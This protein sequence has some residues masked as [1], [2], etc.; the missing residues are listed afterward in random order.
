M[1]SSFRLAVARR[2]SEMRPSKNFHRCGL[3]PIRA[4]RAEKKTDK[5]KIGFH[6]QVIKILIKK[7]KIA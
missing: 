3:G 7:G 5:I 4:S 2:S 1:R 6:I